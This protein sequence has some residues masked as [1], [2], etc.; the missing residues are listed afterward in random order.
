[1]VF[2]R[3]LV[4]AI[5]T[6]GLK[7][8]VMTKW[9]PIDL[10]CPANNAYLPVATSRDLCCSRPSFPRETFLINLQCYT[11]VHESFSFHLL[12]YLIEF[13]RIFFSEGDFITLARMPPLPGLTFFTQLFSIIRSSTSLF[14]WCSRTWV[15]LRSE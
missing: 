4:K 5:S 3:F 11:T 2:M 9:R 7:V 14:G 8:V 6:R 13:D 12:I 1:M 10:L 15:T